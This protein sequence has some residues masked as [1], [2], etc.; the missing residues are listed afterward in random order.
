M[1][2]EP[3][4]RN[5]G[6]QKGSGWI[7][8]VC[9][10]M[11]SGK[12]EELIRRLNRATIAGQ[13]VE[14]FKP[15]IDTRYSKEK[16]VSH[17]DTTIHSTPVHFSGDILLNCEQCDVIGIDEA[18]FFDEGIVDVVNKLANMGKR[19]IV[20]GLDMDFMGRPFTPMDQLMSIAEFITKVHAICMNCGNIASY[21]HRRTKSSKKV[22]LGET[23]I[24]EALCRKCFYEKMA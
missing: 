7:E 2:V 24:Y 15:I 23:D 1:F 17:N 8:V 13:K 14:I 19:V 20:A 11:F 6:N 12:T 3:S 21:S 18:Q 10:S 16:I 4:G 22:V 9:G 5:T